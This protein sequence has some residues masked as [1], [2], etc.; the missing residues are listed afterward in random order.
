M[1]LI[2]KITSQYKLLCYDDLFSIDDNL[3]SKY[4][5][6]ANQTKLPLNK[7]KMSKC[8]VNNYYSKRFIVGVEYLPKIC[9]LIHMSLIE[10]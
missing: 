8:L 6:N 5:T 4:Y 7:T 2:S 1:P 3:F 9:P 10:M